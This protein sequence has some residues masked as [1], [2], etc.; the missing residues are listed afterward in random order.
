MADAKGRRSGDTGVSSTGDTGASATD[1][2]GAG[3]AG[4]TE[5]GPRYREQDAAYRACGERLRDTG[6]RSGLARLKAANTWKWLNG[7]IPGMKGDK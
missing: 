5:A 3:S 1:D 2:T 6:E 7:S 4:D